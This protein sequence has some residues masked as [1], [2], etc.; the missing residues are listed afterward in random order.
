MSHVI[1]PDWC[2]KPPWLRDVIIGSSVDETTK[3]TRGCPAQKQNQFVY[4]NFKID[5]CTLI[6]TS[7]QILSHDISTPEDHYNMLSV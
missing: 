2:T 1:L 6:N 3:S 7:W 5:T 4:G